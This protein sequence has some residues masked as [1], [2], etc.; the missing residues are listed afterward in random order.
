MKLSIIFLAF[1]A[2]LAAQMP[3]MSVPQPP[4]PATAPADPNAV[5][6]SIGDHKITAAQFLELI[7]ALPQQYQEAARGPG[8]RD[9]ARNLVELQVLADQAVKL[10]LDKQ[11]D[12]KLQIEFQRD[13]MLAQAMFMNLQQTSTVS[14]ADV[15][16]YYDAHKGDYENDSQPATY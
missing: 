13:N 5:V 7:K 3:T 16:A 11:P 1:C 12:T 15:Q 2:I 6:I 14:D 10:G 9:F 8:R 4:G